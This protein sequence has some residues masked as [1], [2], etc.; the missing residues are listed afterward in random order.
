YARLPI[1]VERNPSTPR[2]PDEPNLLVLPPD[3][4]AE[5]PD[6]SS[7][8]VH[9]HGAA[10]EIDCPVDPP[11]VTVD[12][13]DLPAV[14]APRRDL[15]TAHHEARGPARGRNDD[16]RRLRCGTRPVEVP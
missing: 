2:R 10:I 15:R 14:G 11:P 12:K 8:P 9:L 7:A 1:H 3:Q 13:P 4:G 5:R 6:S 16:H